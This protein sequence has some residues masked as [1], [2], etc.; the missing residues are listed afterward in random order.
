MSGRGARH[1]RFSQNRMGPGG[2]EPEPDG[3]LPSVGAA[4]GKARIRSPF[5]TAGSSLRSS[6]GSRKWV[7]AD[8]NHRSRPCKGR[9]IATR[10]QTPT[11]R[12]RAAEL[13]LAFRDGTCFVERE[14]T[15]Q[16][17]SGGTGR[18]CALGG[19]GLGTKRAGE[20]TLGATTREHGSNDG[21]R[22]RRSSSR[23]SLISGDSE[24]QPSRAQGLPRSCP[25]HSHTFSLK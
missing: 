21:S 16:P 11:I 5:S 13:T 8:S 2:F 19:R 22:G 6:R 7:R 20:A 18:G 10:P 4:S 15:G 12:N 14:W 3:R 1:V 25:P 24:A 23:K 9:V 17:A